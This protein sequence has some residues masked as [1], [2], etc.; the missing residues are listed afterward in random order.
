M[1]ESILFVIDE[2]ELKY[3]E[4][5][6]L[7][8]NF[9]IIKGFLERGYKV[10]ITTKNS[11]YIKNS[12][13]YTKAQPSFLKNNDIFCEKHFVNHPIN[14]YDVVF[15]RPDPPVN[16]NYI[17]ACYVFDFVDREKTLLINDPSKI[18]DFNEKFH[19]NYFPNYVPKNIVTSSKSLIREFVD[20]NEEAI[21]KPLNRCFGSG[22]YYLNKTDKN[23]NSIVSSLTEN[24]KTPV[25]V[26]KYL[27][28]ATEGDKRVLIV[29]E[30]VY[31]ETIQ[32]LPG[33]RDFKFNT[34]SDNFFKATKL[35]P[36]EKLIA[37][38]VAKTLN[39]QGLYLVGLDVIDEN[40][41]EINVTS[42]CYFFREINKTYG[43]NFHTI[44]M[45]DIINL[46]NNKTKAMT[47]DLCLN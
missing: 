39:K 34:H 27:K 25:M 24:E 15:F 4:F 21:I 45:K 5:N 38:D 19:I 13:G 33:D 1:S 6:D 42:P 23:L 44:V 29:G 31:D 32:K 28:K 22:V 35:T 30:K 3:F 10:D 43:I 40:I 46:I 2:L 8:S 9:W 18:K 7:V 37:E 14:D 41:I 26:Q 20:E 16:V 11:L 17:D 36:R 12:I 47:R